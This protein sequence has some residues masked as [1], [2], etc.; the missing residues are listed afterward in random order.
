[1]GWKTQDMLDGIDGI[2]NLAAASGEDLATT[3]DIVTDALTGFG[4]SASDSSHFA[5]VLAAAS[6]NANTNVGMLGESFKYVSPLCGAMSYSAEDTA[7]ALGL[8]ANSGIKAGQ[9]GTA[10]RGAISSMLKP[11]ENAAN[12][13]ERYGISLIDSSGNAKSLKD[14]MGNLR[15]AFGQMSEAEKTQA[16]ATIFGTEAM[17]GMLAI[18]NASEEDY[19]KLT[20]SIYNCDGSAKQMADTMQNNLQGK[21]TQFKSALEGAGIAIGEN[22]LPALTKIVE[23]ATGVVQGFGELDSSTQS[24]IVNFGLVA[25]AAGP[26]IS[27]IGK[28]TTGIGS[29]ISGISAA[30]SGVGGLGTV[31]GAVFSPAGLIAGAVVGVAALTAGFVVLQN[32]LDANGQ[33]LQSAASSIDDFTGRVRTNRSLWTEIFGEEIE[34]KFTDNF[35]QEKE[36][37]TQGYQDLITAHQNYLND[38]ANLEQGE[39][40]RRLID[41]TADFEEQKTLLNNHLDSNLQSLTDYFMNE[42][43]LTSQQTAE[44]QQLYIEYYHAQEQKFDENQK[45]ILEIQRAAA[46]QKR[47]LTSTEQEEINRL[48]EENGAIMASLTT[49]TTDDMLSAWKLYY[50]NQKV[51][52][53]ADKEQKDL[54]AQD[55]SSAYN[56]LTQNIHKEYA[57][58]EE[59]IRNNV[60]L[61]KEQQDIII[62]NLH[63]RE[64]AETSFTEMYGRMVQE[65][66]MAGKELADANGKA[67]GEIVK[68]LQNGSINSAEFGMTNEQYMAMAIDAMIAAGASS[69]ELTAAIKRIPKDVRAKV[70][71]L[72]EGK[73][74]VDNLKSSIDGIKSKT[75]TITAIMNGN[76]TQ[77]APG[78]G[79]WTLATGTE[80]ANSGLTE[81]AEYGP[82]LIVS[83]SGA[84]AYLATD[85]QLI[86]MEGGERVFNARQT[87]EIL[88]KMQNYS[89]NDDSD[90]LR[91]LI[92]KVDT[93]NKILQEKEF[94]KITENMIQQVDVNGVTDIKDITDQITRYIDKRTI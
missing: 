63:K 68:N 84:S 85:R 64:D 75:V 30:T 1:M 19:N 49:A 9:A 22:L 55:V 83:R 94:N 11:S 21:V 26:V 57:K 71:A 24:M 53:E 76:V 35:D 2:M 58:Q 72:V 89:S 43:G 18:I 74:K 79:K 45:R 3:S 61:N 29:L 14:V 20:D 69:D 34:I 38:R 37:I 8:M 28:L 81:V 31:I 62:S 10:L 42:M 39:A 73:D 90:L 50:E 40:E 25:V 65:N 44:Q 36:K 87:S 6:S 59:D 32:E 56:K 88:N 16:A 5:D 54:Y 92:L 82:E 33:K 67:F 86:N 23:K 60:S 12:A 93:T 70:L 47:E 13:M 17:S 7:I 27:F 41:L 4:L 80:N 15:T 52:M 66:V 78:G 91:T 51:L 77:N 46:D 48:T